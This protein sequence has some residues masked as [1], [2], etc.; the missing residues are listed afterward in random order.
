MRIILAIAVLMNLPFLEPFV[1]AAPHHAKVRGQAH[2]S[3]D[4]LTPAGTGSAGQIEFTATTSFS[5][6]GFGP[7]AEMHTI[8]LKLIVS[9]EDGSVVAKGTQE[10][11]V[12]NAEQGCIKCPVS[13]TKQVDPGVYFLN[14]TLSD[15]GPTGTT[16]KLG[17][18]SV[19]VILN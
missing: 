18:K 2:G 17:A 13:V 10:W 14:A 9:D 8:S 16:T 6:V 1:H 11:T 4:D 19:A 3:I 15:T 7:T 5:G 12:A